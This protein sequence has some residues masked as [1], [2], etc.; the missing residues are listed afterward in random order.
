M[1]TNKL[2]KDIERHYY[3]MANGKQISIMNICKL[4]A[5]VRAMVEAGGDI[6]KSVAKAIEKY[7]EEVA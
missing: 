6:E 5:D 3:K 4:Y 1:K 2:D 7:C